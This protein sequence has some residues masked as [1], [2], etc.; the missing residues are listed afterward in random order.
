MT[1]LAQGAS[2]LTKDTIGGLLGFPW[3][4]PSRNVSV[5][6]SAGIDTLVGAASAGATTATRQEPR[7]FGAGDRCGRRARVMIAVGMQS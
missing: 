1:A 2:S 7:G 4:R 3:T 5:V 6:S